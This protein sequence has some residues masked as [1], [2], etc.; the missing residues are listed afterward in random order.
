MRRLPLVL[1]FISA[2][3]AAQDDA[4]RRAVI[5]RDQ[6][7]AEFAAGVRRGQLE[8]LHQRQLLEATTLPE[9][10]GYARAR[11]TRERDAQLLQLSPPVLTAPKRNDAPLPLPGGPAHGVDP[12]PLQGLGG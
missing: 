5:E 12:I 3:A 2:A 7:S 6:Q 10:A 4:L 11:M 9:P 8:A 1:L